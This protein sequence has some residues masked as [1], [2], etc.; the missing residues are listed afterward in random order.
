MATTKK[1]H[2]RYTTPVGV[3]VFPRLSEPDFKFKKDHGEYSVKLRLT[4]AEAKDIL[5]KAEAVAEESYREQIEAH[6]GKLDKK[7]KPIVVLKA[8]PSYAIEMDDNKENPQPTGYY[9]IAFKMN[10]GYKDKKT[11]EKKKLTVPLFDAKGKACK[12]DVWGGS[13]IKVAYQITPY[14]AAAD[15]KAG[16]S[17]RLGAVQV[18]ELVTRGS[19]NASR[20]GFS[21]EEGSFNAEDE[22]EATAGG[23]KDETGGQADAKAKGDF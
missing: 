23:F 7:G 6:K 17:F 15:V 5:A 12:V 19:G 14:F 2:P 13:S 9:L 11:G 8:E 20:F 16:A 4:E 18:I 1:N 3:A 21:Q 10:G 22:K